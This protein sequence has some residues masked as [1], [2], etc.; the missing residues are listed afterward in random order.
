M[1]LEVYY[2]QDIRNALLAAEQA[3]NV[4]AGAVGNLEEPFAAGFVLGYCA[5]LSTI[6]LVGGEFAGRVAR[7]TVGVVA[8]PRV[9]RTGGRRRQ[10]GAAQ[11]CPESLDKL[12]TGSDEGWSPWR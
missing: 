12:G 3:V 8:L 4:V 2:P 9:H 10:A 6:A 1:G 7:L 11:A 5:A